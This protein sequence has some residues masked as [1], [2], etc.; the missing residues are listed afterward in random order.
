MGAFLKCVNMHSPGTQVKVIMTD[1]GK[2]FV[3]I[4]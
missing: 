3:T 4:L 1:D 2:F